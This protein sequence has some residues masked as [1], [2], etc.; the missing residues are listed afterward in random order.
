MLICGVEILDAALAMARKKGGDPD[1][2][3]V[4]PADLDRLGGRDTVEVWCLLNNIEP[5]FS[6]WTP[7]GQLYL[8]ERPDDDLWPHDSGP[9]P[10]A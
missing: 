1:C 2:L 10:S 8:M 3:V 4:G 6:R 5:C 7:S 9:S